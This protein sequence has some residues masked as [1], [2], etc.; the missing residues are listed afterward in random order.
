MLETLKEE[1]LQYAKQSYREQLFAGTSGNLS[2]FDPDSGLVVITPSSIAYE[3]MTIED[4]V[5]ITLDGTVVEG[6]NRPSSEW[7]VHTAVYKNKPGFNAVVHTHSPYATSFAVT[8][9]RIPFV[10]VEMMLFL[11]GDIPVA[12]FALAGTDGVGESAVAALKN[13]CA[14]LLANHGALAIGRNLERAHISAVYLEDVAKIYAI[15][16]THGTVSVLSKEV[17]AAMREKYGLPADET[18]D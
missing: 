10:L 5:V 4:I 8:H 2:I 1:V 11:G 13:R 18:T 14:C 3:T 17:E 16:K 9:E 6:T 7:R 12:D 15:A